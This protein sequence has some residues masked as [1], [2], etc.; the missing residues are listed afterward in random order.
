MISALRVYVPFFTFVKSD[1]PSVSV[2]TYFAA[3]SEPAAVRDVVAKLTGSFVFAS[4]SLRLILN[5]FCA[6]AA[7][8]I[9][10]RATVIRILTILFF[11]TDLYKQ[12]RRLYCATVNIDTIIVKRFKKIYLLAPIWPLFPPF[13]PPKLPKR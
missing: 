12:T 13:V 6:Y 9:N 1:L 4:T 2:S 3:S 10:E 8:A 11:I 7:V 5:E